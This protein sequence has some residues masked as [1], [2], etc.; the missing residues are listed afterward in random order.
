MSQE[1][2]CVALTIRDLHSRYILTIRLMKRT[3]A[4]AV[5]AVSGELFYHYGLFKIIRSDNCTPFAF[6]NSLLGLATLSAWWMSIGIISNHTVPGCPTQNGAHERIRADI[7]REI[8]WEIPGSREAK[9]TVI[10]LW[11]E[12]YNNTRPHATL[13]MSSSLRFLQKVHLA[14]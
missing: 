11:E 3:T 5:K 9:Q 8:P 4:D 10:D 1:E 12:E 6:S 7:N 13:Q 2:R 14:I